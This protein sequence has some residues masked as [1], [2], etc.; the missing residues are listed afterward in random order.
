M[1]HTLTLSKKRAITGFI[2]VSPFVAGFLIFYIRSI[3][4]TI[5]MSLSDVT[6]GVETGTRGMV[7]AWNG[8]FNYI[9]AFSQHAT[10]KQ[11]L[12][13][14]LLN[15]VI[16]VPLII[17]F[18]LFMALFL[19]QTFRGRTFA[20]AIFFLPVILGAPAISGA[21]SA[22][23]AMMVGGVSP[24]SAEVMESIGAGGTFTVNIGYY[25]YMLGDLAIPPA[26]IGY[27]VDAVLRINNVI[28]ASGVQIVIFVAALQAIPP[29]LYEVAKIEGA[30]SYETFWKITLP[31]VS[32]LIITN[33][34]YTIVDSFA[35]SQVVTLSYNTI[36][37]DFNYGLGSVF[38]LVSSLAVCLV[39]LI[40]GFLL[41]RR[42]FYYT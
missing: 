28:T 21:I 37:T 36:F 26:M 24:A 20:R 35:H 4:T 5:Q 11:D 29:A 19:N 3:I 12:T 38:S 14:S 31:M 23:R 17:F 40:V 7:M 42:T 6:V 32:P 16:D 2:F 10:F 30:T 18:S 25:L 8:F 33:V 27:I 13:S 34:V 1:K 39:L 15:I 22:A 9:R 41:S